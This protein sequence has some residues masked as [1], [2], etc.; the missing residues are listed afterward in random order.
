MVNIVGG[1][2]CGSVRYESEAEPILTAVCHCRH[3][4]KQ[5]SSAFSILVALPKGNLRIEGEPLAAF[6]D[7]GDSGLP[8]IRKFCPK[9][10]SAIVSEVVATPD[11]EWLKAG[12]LDDPS[13]FRPQMHMWCDSAQPWVSIDDT[14]PAY[15]GKPPLGESE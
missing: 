7:E 15:P 12:T 13:W 10:G 4:Q 3:C 8:V 14:I 5:T 1:C 6:E 2:L 9:C 11:L